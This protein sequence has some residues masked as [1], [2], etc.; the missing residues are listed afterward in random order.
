M[1]TEL[2]INAHRIT[3]SLEASLTRAA[4]DWLSVGGQSGPEQRIP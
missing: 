2:S 4:Y 1:N 3:I